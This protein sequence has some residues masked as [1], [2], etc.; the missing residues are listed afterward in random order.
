MF[1][2]RCGGQ[3]ADVATFRQATA[4]VLTQSAPPGFFV[5]REPRALEEAT[6]TAAAA[7]AAADKEG[8]EVSADSSMIGCRLYGRSRCADAR[9]LT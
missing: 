4:S 3:T 6:A 9:R 5:V 8:E 2:A 7:A 1:D